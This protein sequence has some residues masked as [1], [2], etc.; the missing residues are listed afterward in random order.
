MPT[1]S[2]FR[3]DR[4]VDVNSGH[5]NQASAVRQGQD[6]GADLVLILNQR[7]QFGHIEYA[8]HDAN[9]STHIRQ[10]G[11]RVRAAWT[12]DGL[13]NWNYDDVRQY[14]D[15]RADHSAQI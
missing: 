13:W 6:V 4:S 3:D 5:L 9:E 2:G 1:Q 11:N 15:L 12:C 14:H 10:D 7:T 8:D